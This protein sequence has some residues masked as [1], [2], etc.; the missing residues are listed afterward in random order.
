MPRVSAA[1]AVQLSTYDMSKDI[2]LQWTK[3]EGVPTHF[4]ASLLRPIPEASLK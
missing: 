2:I 3:V 1:T 4:G